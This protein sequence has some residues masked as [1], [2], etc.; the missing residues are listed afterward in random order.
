M[1]CSHH[2]R[3]YVL[4]SALEKVVDLLN[5]F[6]WSFTQFHAVTTPHLSRLSLYLSQ[7]CVDMSAVAG[8]DRATDPLIHCPQSTVTFY[9]HFVDSRNICHHCGRDTREPKPWCVLIQSYTNDQF[10][11]KVNVI[12]C[13]SR[14]MP[15]PVHSERRQCHSLPLVAFTNSLILFQ[16]L[17]LS[18][19]CVVFV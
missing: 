12:Y 10:S 9:P 1:S 14:H 6:P 3:H 15:P 4:L 17:C 11:F 7:G 18:G 8:L 16:G 19:S 13:N 2:I 5:Q